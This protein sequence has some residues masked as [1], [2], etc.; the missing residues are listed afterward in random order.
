MNTTSS[1]LL[2]RLRQPADQE[3]TRQAWERFVKLYTP[4]IYHWARRLGLSHQDAP[5]FVQ[6][7]FSGLLQK[8]PEFTYDPHKRFRGWLW[9]V[10]L[11]QWRANRR[12]PGPVAAEEIAPHLENL[13]GPDEIGAVDEVE[14]RQYLVGRAL[15]LMQAEFQPTTWQACWEQVV[16][17]KS[18]AEVAEQLGMSVGAVYVAKSRVLRR[19][20]QELSG[21]LD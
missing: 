15:K 19:L 10:T 21:L 4:L 16:S 9:T 11:N 17:E 12:Q 1:S 8:L 6:D 14:Y 5:D 3:A 18:G 20:R 7:A 13:A 2:E